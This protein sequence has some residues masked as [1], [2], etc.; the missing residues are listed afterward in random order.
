LE[1]GLKQIDHESKL[2]ARLCGQLVRFPTENPPAITTELTRFIKEW[3]ADVSIHSRIFCKEKGKMNLVSNLE[4][5]SAPGLV[6]YGHSDVV[7]AGERKRWGFAPYSGK[8]TDGKVLGRGASDMKGG[9]AAELFALKVLGQLDINL[10]KNLQLVVIPDEENFD[11]ERRLLYKMIDDGVI[12]GQGCI[13][14]EPSGRDRIEV[15]DKGDLWLRVKATG[16]PAH[17]SSPVLGDSAI[18]RLFEGL[19]AI[20]TIWNDEVPIPSDVEGVL[21]FSGD[22]VK[23]TVTA[24]GIPERFEEGKKLLT[25]TSVNVGTVRGGTMINMVPDSAEADIA[26]CLAPGV[27]A[28]KAME[29]VKELLSKTVGLDVS[30]ILSSDPNFTSPKHPLVTTLRE[31]HQS[32]TGRDA[33]PFLTTATSDAHAFRLRGI[34]TVLFGPG[35]MSVIH[36]Y[37]EFVDAKDLTAFAKVYFETAIEFC[38]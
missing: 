8:V 21:P 7:P 1:K 22:V 31:T 9:L 24:M 3:L 32:I 14:A 12:A 19:K 2:L 26:L 36:G 6:L 30:I 28:A 10:R 16:K 35:D 29:R 4:K 38:I 33:K 15:G 27:T 13:M 18:L 23:Q 37:D 5:K 20:G 25:H 11:A 17:G 34:P